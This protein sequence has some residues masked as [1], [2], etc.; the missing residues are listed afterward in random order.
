MGGGGEG[1]KGARRHRHMPDASDVHGAGVDPRP[2]NTAKVP[3]R[4]RHKL[5]MGKKEP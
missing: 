3:H 4:A 1:G 2:P 5:V